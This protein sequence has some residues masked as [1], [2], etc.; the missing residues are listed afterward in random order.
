MGRCRRPGSVACF[1][2]FS[3]GRAL[4]IVCFS[5]K[6]FVPGVHAGKPTPP[7]NLPPFEIAPPP[8]HEPSLGPK[9]IG[10]TR[11]R[12]RQRKFLQGADADL[13]CDTM[14]QFW[15]AIPPPSGGNCHFM[16]VPAPPLGGGTGLTKGGRLQAGGGGRV[17]VWSPVHLVSAHPHCMSDA[18]FV[19]SS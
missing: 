12:R 9:G 14:V 17:R 8:P 3:A 18:P 2:V 10:N 7:C 11:C 15:G 19:G 4:Y 16:T 6:F 5:L 1:G 13:H